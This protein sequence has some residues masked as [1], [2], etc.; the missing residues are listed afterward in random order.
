M[1]PDADHFAFRR[2]THNERRATRAAAIIFD[3]FSYAHSF[4]TFLLTLCAAYVVKQRHTLGA[5]LEIRLVFR[6]EPL[7]AS[8][9]YASLECDAFQQLLSPF[10]E[11]VTNSTIG[12]HDHTHCTCRSYI[13]WS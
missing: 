8:V 4:E 2:D 9:F 10:H 11:T 12:E 5:G 6:R 1:S 3:T 7:I 13:D